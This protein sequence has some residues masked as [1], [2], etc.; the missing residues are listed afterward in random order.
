MC[1]S[2]YF[3]LRIIPLVHAISSIET[4]QNAGFLHKAVCETSIFESSLFIK[5]FI[6]KKEAVISAYNHKYQHEN[7]FYKTRKQVWTYKY[8]NKKVMN[9]RNKNKTNIRTIET[10]DILLFEISRKVKYSG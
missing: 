10:D 6:A 2:V 1:C 5:R 9:K 4:K 3:I 8:S 7:W